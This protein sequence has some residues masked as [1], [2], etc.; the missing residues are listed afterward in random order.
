MKEKKFNNSYFDFSSVENKYNSDDDE[1]ILSS[2]VNKK[3]NGVNIFEELL[4]E[5]Y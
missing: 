4:K 1:L 2:F 5:D 3:R